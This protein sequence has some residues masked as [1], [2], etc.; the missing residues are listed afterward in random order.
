MSLMV[1]FVG[2]DS[3]LEGLVFVGNVLVWTFSGPPAKANNEK[4]KDH[5]LIRIDFVE[6]EGVVLGLSRAEL[7]FLVHNPAAR[8]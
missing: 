2:V 3:K 4:E 6:R 5:V 8:K 1:A 7:P